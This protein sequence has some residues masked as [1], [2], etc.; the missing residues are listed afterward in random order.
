VDLA[1]QAP[2]E[3]TTHH[4]SYDPAGRLLQARTPDS[5]VQFS[6]DA[7]GRI[8]EESLSSPG[9]GAGTDFKHTL[10]HRYGP[11]GQRQSTH[12]PFAG[13][14]DYLSYGP[15]HVHHGACQGSCRLIHAH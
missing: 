5:L 8:T 1:G 12:H 2:I 11:L 15:G 14:V 9:L 6:R 4:F 13:E 7:L 3:T 10:R